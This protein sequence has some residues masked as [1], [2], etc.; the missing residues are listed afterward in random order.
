VSRAIEVREDQTLADLHEGL[1]E[2]VRMVGR[3][4]VLVLA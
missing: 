2:G 1:S 4:P 3:S